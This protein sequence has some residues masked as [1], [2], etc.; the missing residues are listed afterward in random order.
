MRSPESAS[1]LCLQPCVHF[2]QVSGD[3]L[4]LMETL[5]SFFLPM[6]ESGLW[7]R[8]VCLLSP[9][10]FKKVIFR[11]IGQLARVLFPPG[12]L[13]QIHLWTEHIHLP[14]YFRSCWQ[15]ANWIPCKAVSFQLWEMILIFLKSPSGLHSGAGLTI[16][17]LPSNNFNHSTP[18]A[19]GGLVC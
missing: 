2:W 10:F 19:F 6:S 13:G 17:H 15:R 16:L 18:L 8:D 11:S 12:L 3:C 9:Y 5:Y 4:S 7:T 1:R 14:L